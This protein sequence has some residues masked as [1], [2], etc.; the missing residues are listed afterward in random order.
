[1]KNKT[2]D[3]NNLVLVLASMSVKP[4]LKDEIW[5]CYGYRKS[6]KHGHI[7][8]KMFP[9][10]FQLDNFIAVELITLGLVDV[11]NGIKKSTKKEDTK[12]L[13]SLG[14]LDTIITSTKYLV[15]ADVLLANLFTT[16]DSYLKG[17]K[18]K[19]YEPIIL[20]AVKILNKKDFA[21]FMVGTIT[22]L[23]SR[24]TNGYL[25]NS[26]YIKRL[27]DE[28]TVQNKLKMVMPEEKWRKYGALISEKILN[29]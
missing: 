17:D 4:L 29:T 7:L 16:Y 24:C 26:D 15:S 10:K 6:P 8:D 22:L 20:K 2:N 1:M 3:V 25:L 23:P 21:K 12:L 18:S 13:I 11:L 5:R 14:V 19:L 28:S 9:K 27:I